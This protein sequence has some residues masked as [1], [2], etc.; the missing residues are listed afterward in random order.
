MDTKDR[1]EFLRF[2]IALNACALIVFIS[3]IITKMVI[4]TI[5]G[6][7]LLMGALTIRYW[8]VPKKDREKKNAKLKLV[9]V[10]SSEVFGI[11][12]QI[13]LY[14]DKFIVWLNT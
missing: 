7:V 4:L 11:G 1:T 9:E 13:K 3:A 14:W 10:K 12:D 6:W 2:S 8:Y 5:I